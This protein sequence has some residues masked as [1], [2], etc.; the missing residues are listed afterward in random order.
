MASNA[1]NVLGLMLNERGIVLA[2]VVAAKP[3][4]SVKRLGRFTFDAGVS[5]DQPDAAGKALRAFLNSHG[6]TASRAVVGVPARLLI[7]HER[8]LPPIGVTESG[9][10][11]RLA[12]ER[13]SLAES[14]SLITDY[15]GAPDP[16]NPT[17]VLLVGMLRPR[18]D[19]IVKLL[20]AAELG[21]AAI[22][23]TSLA[24]ARLAGGDRSLLRLS[25]EGAELVLQQGGVPRLIQPL[26]ADPASWWAV[27]KRTLTLRGATKNDLVVCDG[28]GLTATQFG[29]LSTRLATP[30]R[31]LAGESSALGLPSIDPAARN[32][33]A[34]GMTPGSDVAAIALAMA[35][36]DRKKL[37]VDFAD[38][39]LKEI[40]RARFGRRT[41]LAA[42]AALAVVGGCVALVM[43]V[44]SRQSQEAELNAQLKKNDPEVKAAQA[45][46]DRV[47]FGR[48]FFETR[49]PYLEVLKKIT[50]CF[51]YE[52]PIWVSSL[53]IKEGQVTLQGRA[54]DVNHDTR[55]ILALLDRL[56]A[57]KGFSQVQ[58]YN[59]GDTTGKDQTRAFTIGFTV[60]AMAG[61]ESK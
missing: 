48:T 26:S 34:Q 45:V 43:Q 5:L 60:D 14:G 56:K 19:R 28:V 9:D 20:A 49:P 42:A 59:I 39:K 54:V 10:I 17:K 1:T 29:E 7:A 4:P 40:P 27:A 25:D 2:H 23:P 22:C 11:L 52:E 30:T 38:T 13:M 6:F 35:G 32:G 44:N 8:D 36:L 57:T 31:D 58:S 16:K 41:I 51:N 61:M 46:I 12:A 47:N 53:S 24:A 55:L 18:Y 50:L 21:I 3:A 37:S 33:A 15:A